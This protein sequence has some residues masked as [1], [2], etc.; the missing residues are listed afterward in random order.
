MVL[1]LLH[2]LNG[3]EDDFTEKSMDLVEGLG[4]QN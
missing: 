1:H 3:S 2:D 4:M